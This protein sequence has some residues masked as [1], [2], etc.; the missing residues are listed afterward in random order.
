[1]KKIILISFIGISLISNAQHWEIGCGLGATN[2]RTDISNFNILNTRVGADAFFRYNF[3]HVW[4]ARVDLKYL[5]L[6]GKDSHNSDIISKL[7]NKSFH[8]NIFQTSFNIEYNFLDFRDLKRKVRFSPYLTF[9]LGIS[10]FSMQPD[11]INP[12]KIPV[13]PTIP[14]GFGVK[15]MLNKN[16]N[17]GAKY[18]C[19]VLY[20]DKLDGIDEK[21]PNT[22]N[23]HF[24]SADLATND[25]IHYFCINISYTFYKI[26]C[27]P[28]HEQ[29]LNSETN[30][31]SK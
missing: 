4:V 6:D 24:R 17:I 14:F 28:H 10:V 7:R 31:I 16:W 30:K 21:N 18:E 5:M 3:N 20:N 8:A 12:S 2:S 27:P 29:L 26:K 23:P 11:F 15:Y 13:Y 1:M 19:S 25:W 22:I 9:G